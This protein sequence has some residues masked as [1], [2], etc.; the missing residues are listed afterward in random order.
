MT[1]VPDG[2]WI[3]HPGALLQLPDV[4]GTLTRKSERTVAYSVSA[5]GARR[6][7][8]PA[9]RAPLREWTVSLPRLRPEEAAVLQGLLLQTDPPYMWVDP[10]SQVTNLLSP[11][12][13]GLQTT[14]PVL[15][16]VG[17]Q[18]L[19]GGGYAPTGVANPT[20][21]VVRIEPAP[22]VRERAV[23]ISAYLASAAGGRVAA[24][25]LDSNAAT[26]GA[27]VTSSPVVG[28]QT[29]QRA[30]LTVAVPPVG[31]VA[32][33]VQVTGAT[34]IAQPAVTWTSELLPYGIGG[35]AP[36]V[37]VSG[38][39][40]AIQAAVRVAAGRRWADVSFTVSEVG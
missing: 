6:A 40:E 25:F 23:T 34:V 24:R 5:A 33:E 22:V 39:D 38:V 30:S 4:E 2:Y 12:A 7:Y 35:G 26:V 21:D 32:V 37:V 1:R 13:S 29:L 16:P 14:I 20:G 15:A 18:P 28:T 17:R 36:Q 8:L 11:K 3:G 10:W 27:I 31:A 19:A 9:R